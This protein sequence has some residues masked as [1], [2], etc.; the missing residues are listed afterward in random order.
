MRR[1]AALA[2]AAA[3]D[4]AQTPALAAACLAAA[5]P[6]SRRAASACGGAVAIRPAHGAALTV[7]LPIGGVG[8]HNLELP[9]RMTLWPHARPQLRPTPSFRSLAGPTR[10]C[11]SPSLCR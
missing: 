5:P 1:T 11:T 7:R 2:R 10:R 3:H 4:T 6:C 9:L 8:A